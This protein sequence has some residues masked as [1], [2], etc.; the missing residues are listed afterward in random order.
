METIEKFLQ[1]R[2]RQSEFSAMMIPRYLENT[3]AF[4]GSKNF[5]LQQGKIFENDAKKCKAILNFL[6]DYNKR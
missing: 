1:K 6:K 4:L 3:N 5:T 2:I